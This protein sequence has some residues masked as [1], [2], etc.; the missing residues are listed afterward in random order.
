VVFKGSSKGEIFCGK[1]N[2]MKPFHGKDR[3]TVFRIPACQASLRGGFA[4]F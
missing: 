4:V 3:N 2:E 1:A